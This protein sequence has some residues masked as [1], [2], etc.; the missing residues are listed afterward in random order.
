MFKRGW[1]KIHEPFV[2]LS[3]RLLAI[4]VNCPNEMGQESLLNFPLKLVHK[5]NYEYE[6]EDEPVSCKTSGKGIPTVSQPFSYSSF[7][8]ISPES[9][10]R[11]Y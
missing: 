1:L 9:G 10:C 11:W 3:N 2:K 4:N 5:V 7:A 6:K 8:Q